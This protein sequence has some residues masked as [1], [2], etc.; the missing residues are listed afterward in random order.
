[1]FPEARNDVVLIEFDDARAKGLELFL[2]YDKGRKV[3]WWLSY[4][5]ARAEETIRNLTF[6]GLLVERT[7]T[8]RRL[9]NQDHTLYADVNYR[10]NRNWHVNLS[11]QYHTGWPLTKYTYVANRGYSDPPAP[12][13]H[14]AATHHAFRAEDYPA[15]HR[16]DLRV[17]RNFRFR[18][19]A[20]KAYIHIVNLYNRLNMRKFDVDSRNDNEQLVAD[21]QG[22]YQ[23]FADNTEWFGILPVMGLSLEF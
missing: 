4:A 11:W 5:R 20:L 8:L 3:S 21:G 9:N 23:Y 7:G 12:D 18:G 2:K 19:G 1:M 22:S 13:L 14:M 17:N 16:M 15:Y 10:P 6:E